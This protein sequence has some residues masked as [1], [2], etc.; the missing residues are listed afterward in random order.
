MNGS[1]LKWLPWVLCAL[2]ITALAAVAL[3]APRPTATTETV[4]SAPPPMAPVLSP[5]KPSRPKRLKF[6][7]SK[8]TLVST[9]PG[10][11]GLTSKVVYSPDGKYLAIGGGDYSGKLGRD[12]TTGSSYSGGVIL[13]D[14]KTGAPRGTIRTPRI[15]VEDVAFSADGRMMAT[16]GANNSGDDQVQIW[17]P[18]TG[19]ELLSLPGSRSSG[20]TFSPDGKTLAVDNAFWDITTSTQSIFAPNILGYSSGLAFSRDGKILATE[21][22]LLLIPQHKVILIRNLG[23]DTLG[24]VTNSAVAISPTDELAIAGGHLCDLPGGKIIPPKGDYVRRKSEVLTVAFSPDGKVLATGSKDSLRLWEL[25]SFHELAD[26]GPG[27]EW[28]RTV[29][30]SPDGRRLAAANDDGSVRVW[31]CEELR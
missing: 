25:P 15:Q 3:Q 23:T 19:R 16:A 17:D 4:A 5:D 2:L 18:D 10:V 31:Q 20:V 21:N 29:A 7:R 28:T 8:W 26:L 12:P 1:K 30:F 22:G 27:Q 9:R 24:I 13:L 14:A 6:N 11:G